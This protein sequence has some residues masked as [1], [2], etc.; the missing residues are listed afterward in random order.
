MIIV[1]YDGSEDSQ[2]AVDR[3]AQ[4]FPD[5]PATVLTIWETYADTLART[6]FGLAYDT[7]D[8]SG[9][10]DEQVLAQTK[11]TADEG[12]QRLRDAGV[13]AESLVEDRV[14]GI[15]R[16]V[17]DVARRLDAE[18]IVVGT[19]GRGGAKS[20]LLGSVSHDLVQQGDRPVVVV[21]SEEIAREREGRLQ[22]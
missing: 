1:C 6:G 21:P 4:L 7:T 20:L 2:A 12:A 5:K 17:L 11:K 15:A 3:T 16:T 18:A 19:R 10:L 13:K 22:S 14:G 8:D 9:A